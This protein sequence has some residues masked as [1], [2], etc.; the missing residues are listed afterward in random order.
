MVSKEIVNPK[1]L[2]E[3]ELDLTEFI[4]P[5]KA[6]V[7]VESLLE[8]VVRDKSSLIRD[9]A[10][11]IER[12]RREIYGHHSL[13]GKTSLTMTDAFQIVGYMRNNLAR[14]DQW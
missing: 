2:N 14:Y 4:F 9:P 8:H 12:M 3:L 5:Q 10:G 13:I 6:T 7:F 1:S 11:I